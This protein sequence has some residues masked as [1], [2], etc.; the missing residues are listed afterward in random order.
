LELSVLRVA[1]AESDPHTLEANVHAGL[2]AGG[3][4]ARWIVAP[5]GKRA[6]VKPV[7]EVRVLLAKRRTRA[8]VQ[9]IRA[10]RDPAAAVEHHP[11]AEIE[12]VEEYQRKLD[13]LEIAGARE[14]L[15]PPGASLRTTIAYEHRRRFTVA[16]D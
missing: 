10:Q 4:T 16:N 6:R 12:Q 14:L 11:Q 9:L 13:D 5:A 15:F 7:D 8:E 3:F 2:L 1:S